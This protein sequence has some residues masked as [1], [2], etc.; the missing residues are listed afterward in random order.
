MDEGQ[1]IHKILGKDQWRG[2]VCTV[3]QF[4]RPYNVENFLISS[5]PFGFSRT[6]FNGDCPLNTVGSISFQ[7]VIILFHVAEA[8]KIFGAVHGREKPR[9]CGFSLKLRIF[10]S[11]CMTE[12]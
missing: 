2:T 11:S 10:V 9:S 1:W 4:W 6:L 3:I 5:E 7:S 8:I 12:L